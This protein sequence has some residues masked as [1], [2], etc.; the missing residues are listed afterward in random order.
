MQE[1]VAYENDSEMAD[2]RPVGVVEEK[3]SRLTDELD[4]LEQRI[5]RLI[6]RISPILTPEMEAKDMSTPESIPTQSP[7][8]VDLN[9]RIRDVNRMVQLVSSTSDRVEL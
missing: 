7:M 9:S 4:V 3:F 8:A 1:G 2:D 6:N 5:N